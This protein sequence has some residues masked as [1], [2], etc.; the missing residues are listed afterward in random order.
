VS[1]RLGEELGMVFK[2][3]N[4]IFEILAHLPKTLITEAF[5]G[6]GPLADLAMD[7]SAPTKRWGQAGDERGMLYLMR[8]ANDDA[9]DRERVAA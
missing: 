2:K 7:A 1:V 6:G 4:P 5:S 8:P 3:S 9:G